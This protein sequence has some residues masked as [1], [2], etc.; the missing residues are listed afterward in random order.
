MF[1]KIRT[2]PH[3]MLFAIGITLLLVGG[4][5]THIFPFGIWSI[6]MEGIIIFVASIFI[7]IA[8]DKKHSNNN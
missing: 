6:L 8:S 7:V 3:K 1:K 2:L 5:I 4:T